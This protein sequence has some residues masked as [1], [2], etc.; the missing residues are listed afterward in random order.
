MVYSSIFTCIADFEPPFWTSTLDPHFGLPFWT[1][2]LDPNFFSGG[3]GGYQHPTNTL[4]PCMDALLGLPP[5]IKSNNGGIP[6]L[7][8]SYCAEAKAA[9]KNMSL[10]FRKLRF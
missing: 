3:G 7:L 1:P 5:I 9:G 4:W 6:A 10:K 2:I 8:K